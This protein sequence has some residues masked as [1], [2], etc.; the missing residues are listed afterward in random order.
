MNRRA[1]LATTFV[2]AVPF[3]SGCAIAPT[4]PT[5]S[6]R[7]AAP[8][9]TPIVGPTITPIPATPSAAPSPASAEAPT[10]TLAPTVAPTEVPVAATPTAAPQASGLVLWHD[11]T[12][13]NDALSVVAKGLPAPP[14]GQVY[15][16]WLVG[17]DRRLALGKLAPTGS[18]DLSLTYASPAHVNLLANWDQVFVAQEAA[19]G[20]SQ[21]SGN[22]ILSGALPPQA[23]VHVR[24]LLVSFAGTPAKLGFLLGLRQ[25]TDILLQHAQFLKDAFDQESLALERLHGEHIVNL[26]EGS[27][28]PHYGDLD[29]DGRVDNPGDGF[30]VLPNGPQS[31]YVQGLIDH[32]GFAAQTPDAT[33]LIKQHAASVAVC[34]ENTRARVTEIRDR[35]L[36]IFQARGAADPKEDVLRILALAQQTV[37]GVDVSGAGQVLPIPGGG[38]VLTAYQHAQLMASIELT[39]GGSGA[40]A[41]LNPQV[42]AAPSV[43]ATVPAGANPPAPPTPTSASSAVVTSPLPAA[44]P[45]PAQAAA[46]PTAGAAVAVSIG[47]VFF[48]PKVIQVPVGATVIWRQLGHLPHTVT[49]DD[50]S[51][52]SD[53]LNSGATFKVTFSKPGTYQYFCQFHGGQGGVGMA[54]VVK[55]Q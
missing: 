31:G 7:P 29:G 50:S 41:N 38:G 20:G 46:R 40:A 48:N 10:A 12:L 33:D 39:P 37:Q 11:Q 3:V 42:P 52:G 32:A 26:I 23:L 13:L 53:T 14:D 15:A 9:P 54:A 35:A 51:F 44:S 55:V 16:A 27:K 2:A 28:G 34:G 45:T 8:Q 24:H 18:G 6:P 36:K 1:F 47:D 30:G 17:G 5:P 22:V 21:G 4:A 43:A 25:Q 19:A 49:A